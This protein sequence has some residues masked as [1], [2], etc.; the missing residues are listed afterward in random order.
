MAQP[1]DEGARFAVVVRQGVKAKDGTDIMLM[2]MGILLQIDDAIEVAGKSQVGAVPDDD[3]RRLEKV[4]PDV[5]AATAALPGAAPIL[6]AWTFTTMPVTEPMARWLARRK[7]E[8]A[9]G[10]R[11]PSARPPGQLSP[12]AQFAL[13][14]FPFGIAPVSEVSDVGHDRVA[15]VP[16]SADARVA[17]DG[18]HEV[19]NIEFTAMTSRRTSRRPG[20]CPS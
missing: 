13:A 12:W 1:L 7:H 14:D 19:Q 17:Q 5:V 16:R 2:P 11:L 18:G 20:R 9:D 10:A 6:A 3:A 8:R 15:G 4:R